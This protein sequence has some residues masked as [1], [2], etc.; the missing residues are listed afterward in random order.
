VADLIEVDR[1]VGHGV[2]LALLFV[3]KGEVDLA[4]W[5]SRFCGYTLGGSYTALMVAF[6]VSFEASLYQNGECEIVV[7]SCAFRRV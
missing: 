6:A 1:G 2:A 3:L 5:R 4:L 7:D